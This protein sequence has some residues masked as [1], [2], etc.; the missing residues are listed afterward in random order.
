MVAVDK[1]TAQSAEG[2]LSQE[3]GQRAKE[4]SFTKYS[5]SLMGGFFYT[6][7]ST[8]KFIARRIY[9]DDRIMILY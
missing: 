1:R 8:D 2:R 4:I 3:N 6:E 9:C 7:N 5:R